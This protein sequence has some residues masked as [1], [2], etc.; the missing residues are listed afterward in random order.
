MRLRPEIVLNALIALVLGA[1]VLVIV[2]IF[3]D[4]AGASA[5][6]TPSDTIAATAPTTLAPA[7]TTVLPETQPTTDPG[8]AI[9]LAG[10]ID[11]QEAL[12]SALVGTQVQFL[13]AGVM[14]ATAF[15]LK[16]SVPGLRLVDGVERADEATIGV[17][18]T[19]TTALLVTQAQDGTWYCVAA[20]GVE[21]VTFYGRGETVEEVGRFEACN[22]STEGW[23]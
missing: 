14:P 6:E 10:S 16:G 17:V 4:R 3:E 11:A 7:A 2:F 1:N 13:Q 21:K 18:T 23:N 12:R 9:P 22:T 5:T 15:E 8:G 20:N 19:D